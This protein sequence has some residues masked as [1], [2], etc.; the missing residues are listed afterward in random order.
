VGTDLN[1]TKQKMMNMKLRTDAFLMDDS[2]YP[3]LEPSPTWILL[4]TRTPSKR[5]QVIYLDSPMARLRS[6]HWR[7]SGRLGRT[8]AL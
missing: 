7:V 2:S 1:K 6:V 3:Y 5:T 4:E 8:P